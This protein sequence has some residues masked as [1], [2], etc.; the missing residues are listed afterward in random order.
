MAENTDYSTTAALALA[1]SRCNKRHLPTRLLE[2]FVFRHT[3]TL[4]GTIKSRK[5][6][7]YRINTELL[8]QPK[9]RRSESPRAC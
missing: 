7:H 5:V 6:S 8:Q 2:L 3:V 9:L 4:Q 1:R